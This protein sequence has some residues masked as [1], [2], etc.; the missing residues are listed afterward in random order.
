MERR[1]FLK[2]AAAAPWVAAAATTTTWAAPKAAPK[3]FNPTIEQARQAAL[4]VLKPSPRDLEHGL[5]LHAAS[6]VFE[7]YGFSPSATLDVDALAKAIEGGASNQELEDLQ[8][9]MRMTRCVTDPAQ[10][11]E[12]QEGWEASGVTCIF[13]NAGEENQ[14]ALRILRRLARFTFVTDMLR[15][16]V[17]KAVTPDDVVTAK[18]QGRH[19]LYFSSNAVPLQEQWVNA[20]NELE[21]I[22]VYFQLGIRMMHLTYNRRNM[23]GDGCAETTNGGLSDF[24]RQVVAE[25]N[26][27][28]VIVDVAHSGW[29][30]GLDAARCSTRPMVASHSA[31]DGLYHHIRAKPDKLIK[32]IADTG[33]LIGIC[34]VP[35]FLGGKGD[36]A[37][38]MD[39]IA[40]AVK[41]VGAD[42]V[43]IGTD[44][45]YNC[46][47]TSEPK[48]KMPKRGPS[49]PRWEY[50]WPSDAFK[51]AGNGLSMSWTNWPMFT[52]GMVQRGMRDEDIQ[53][54]LGGNVMR[55][56]RAALKDTTGDVR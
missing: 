15:T 28:G 8:E 50:L 13:Q 42:H 27:V 11:A 39:Q 6:L 35:S 4:D 38:M 17:A 51:L 1:S 14:A 37:A 48:T 16:F 30:T 18:R 23:I 9:E 52:V 21:L 32:A 53:K 31:C 55:V 40:Y 7:S 36:L 43:A 49:R 54:I 10:R 19:C 56:A 2:S 45:A 3:K 47:K 12:Y 41:L 29:Q 20:K 22:R 44:V 24:G 34:C 25:M 26:R 5:E 33:G 46:R